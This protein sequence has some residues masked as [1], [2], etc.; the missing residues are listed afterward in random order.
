[1]ARTVDAD[2]LDAGLHPEGVEEAMVVVRSALARVGGDVEL[3]GAFHQVERVD[4]DLYL[5]FA[6]ERVGLALLDVRIGTVETDPVGAEHREAEHEVG[7]RPLCA[8]LQAYAHR[9]AGMKD[10]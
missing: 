8:H 7:N 10:V 6:R 9:L 5:G 3:V 4:M 1:M 2:I